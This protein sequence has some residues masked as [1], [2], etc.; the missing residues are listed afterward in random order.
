MPSTEDLERTRSAHGRASAIKSD[1]RLPALTRHGAN[2]MAYS[3]LQPGLRYFFAS[4]DNYIAYR[5][6]GRYYAALGDPLCPRESL[7]ALLKQ[8][9]AHCQMADV[10]ALIAHASPAT[11]AIAHRLGFARHV[12]GVEFDL[13]LEH[14]HLRGR[15]KAFLRRACNRAMRAGLTVAER[16]AGDIDRA[17][18]QQVSSQWLAMKGERTFEFMVRPLAMGDEFDVRTFYGFLDGRMVGFVNFD[19]VYQNGALIGYYQQH[20]RYSEAAPVGTIDRI[21]AVAVDAFREQGL[22]VL[23]L[24]LCPF[25]RLAAYRRLSSNPVF[26]RIATRMSERGEHHYPFRGSYF[27]KSRY[28]GRESPVFLLEKP[29]SRTGA[30]GVLGNITKLYTGMSIM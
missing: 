24:G 14:H 5:P 4:D 26:F 19:P 29:G 22:S 6:A 28:R 27:H 18:K 17:D 9:D 30:L 10:T 21:T 1:P 3:T 11:A 2:V 12:I 7:P 16:R 8:F 13:Q 15:D 23:K 25:A 20:M